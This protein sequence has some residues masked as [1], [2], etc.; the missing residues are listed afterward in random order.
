MACF[1][2]LQVQ[3]APAAGGGVFFSGRGIPTELPCGHCVG[4]RKEQARQWA[5]RCMHEAAMHAESC[6]ITV[7]YDDEHLPHPPSLAKR[8]HQLFMKRL[9]KA[10]E[11][12]KISFFLSGEYG[13][14]YG[15][16]HYHAIIFGWW[17]EDCVLW[18]ES[19][20][21][22]RLYRSEILERIW[23]LGFASVGG[24]TFASAMYIASYVV[25]K[26]MKLTDDPAAYTWLD[27]E[28]GEFVCL[29]PEY[30][31]MS[32]RPAIGKRWLERYGESDAYRHDKVI[33]GGVEAALPRYYDKQLASSDPVRSEGVKRTR[34]VNRW[35]RGRADETKARRRVRE[36]VEKARLR[37][38]KRR[39]E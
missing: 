4:C 22:V 20:D 27:P 13:D 35:R 18:K 32:R 17:P 28:T 7:T 8:E 33:T 5:T 12:K 3:Y 29:E 19:G 31:C 15:R 39:V 30:A 21:G 23:G 34:M 36:E 24:V 9:R 2:P 16:P 37:L 25:K 10:L 26:Q 11:P 1:R 38:K 14:K 6:F